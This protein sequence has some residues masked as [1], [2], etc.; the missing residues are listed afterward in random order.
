[1]TILYLFR[2]VA[3]IDP[4]ALVCVLSNH[5]W[6]LTFVGTVAQASCGNTD[7]DSPHEVLSYETKLFPLSEAQH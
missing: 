3:N 5:L 7:S 6:L 4:T 1:M 2:N